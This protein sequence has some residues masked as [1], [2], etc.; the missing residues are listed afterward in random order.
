MR[1]SK[2]HRM[3][4]GAFLARTLNL[5]ATEPLLQTR[6]DAIAQ[7]A[8]QLTAMTDEASRGFATPASGVKRSLKKA[9]RLRAARDEQIQQFNAL[10]R[11]HTWHLE[12]VGWTNEDGRAVPAFV[13]MPT[14]ERGNEATTMSMLVK[15]AR[16]GLLGRLRKCERCSKWFFSRQPWGKFCGAACRKKHAHSTDDFKEQNRVYQGDHYRKFYS[17]NKKYYRKGWS[18]A[19]VREML[20]KRR[21]EKHHAK[22]R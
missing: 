21:Q 17:P 15:L 20:K 11:P 12:L 14:W 19:E 3:E 10:L 13:D 16:A 22:R 4:D 18:P 8:S 1:T 6:C 2:K 5:A 9:A 7:V